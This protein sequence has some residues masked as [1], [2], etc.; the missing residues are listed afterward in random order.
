MGQENNTKSAEDKKQNRIAGPVYFSKKRTNTPFLSRLKIVAKS[1]DNLNTSKASIY[2]VANIENEL[3]NEEGDNNSIKVHVDR[4]EHES[5]EG[6]TCTLNKLNSQPTEHNYTKSSYTRYH[7]KEKSSNSHSQHNLSTSHNTSFLPHKEKR[8]SHL[9]LLTTTSNNLSNGNYTQHKEKSG[10]QR[11]LLK[12]KIYSKLSLKKLNSL[13]RNK[14]KSQENLKILTVNSVDRQRNSNSPETK[15]KQSNFT[16][17]LSA[18][19]LCYP[20][21]ASIDDTYVEYTTSRPR[22]SRNNNSPGHNTSRYQFGFTNALGSPK[23]NRH[24]DTNNFKNNKNDNN[25]LK[26]THGNTDFDDEGY[27]FF[28]ETDQPTDLNPHFNNFN[29]FNWS[30]EINKN[31]SKSLHT[32]SSSNKIK[33]TMKSSAKANSKGYISNHMGLTNLGP[34]ALASASNQGLMNIGL[35][36]GTEETLHRLHD[37]EDFDSSFLSNDV[38]FDFGNE[39]EEECGGLQRKRFGNIFSSFK[40]KGKY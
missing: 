15:P 20:A 37:A 13:G 25:N 29:N 40:K 21:L 22:N 3:G 2:K 11:S 34:E 30:T 14:D 18:G 8:S 4:S 1:L 32:E 19:Q 16:A 5:L 33:N 6:D 10:S 12:E 35:G 38:G 31:R 26:H 39:G 24:R 9:S 36:T 27:E 17:A 23:E 28:N 7:P